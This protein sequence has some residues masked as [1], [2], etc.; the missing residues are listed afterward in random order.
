MTQLGYDNIFSAIGE[1][2]HE[3]AD[4]QFRADLLLTLRRMFE[5]KGW[6][7]ADIAAALGIP[8][9]RVSELMRGKIDLFSADKLIGFLA[10]L[11]LRLRPRF[12]PQQGLACDIIPISAVSA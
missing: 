10:R 4:L 11:N 12:D 7:Q 1:D 2:D 8:Q 3:A 6:K 9:P 5:E